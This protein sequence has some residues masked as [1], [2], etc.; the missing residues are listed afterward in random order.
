[1]RALFL[2]ISKMS[3]I[4]GT[5]TVKNVIITVKQYHSYNG[6]DLYY[7]FVNLSLN[8]LNKIDLVM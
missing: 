8:V 4:S 3:Q 6:F 7:Y 2:P 1:M 5:A